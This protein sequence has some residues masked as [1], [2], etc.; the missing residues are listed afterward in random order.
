MKKMVLPGD[1]LS[2]SE[3]LLPG[4]GTYEEEGIIRAAIVGL[5][6]KSVV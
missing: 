1:E 4:E 3:E 5:D 6:R 2:T